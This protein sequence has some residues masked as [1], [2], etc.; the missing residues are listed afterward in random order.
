[1]PV[2][3]TSSLSHCLLNIGVGTLYNL[4]SHSTLF[5][6]I[7]KSLYSSECVEGME[8]HRGFEVSTKCPRFLNRIAPLWSS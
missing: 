5:H 8:F 6:Y 4:F 3:A 1:M 2:A 7:I